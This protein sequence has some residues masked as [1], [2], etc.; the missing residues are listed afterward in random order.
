M[1]FVV[2]LS[3]LLL[4]GSFFKHRQVP[5][6][7]MLLGDEELG[8]HACPLLVARTR[9]NSKKAKRIP[10]I[11]I[12]TESIIPLRS[13]WRTGYKNVQRNADNVNKMWKNFFLSVAR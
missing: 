12:I 3:C 1:A 9:R 6:S 2:G 5:D 10:Q 13:Y 4:F 11:R 8:N 7:R